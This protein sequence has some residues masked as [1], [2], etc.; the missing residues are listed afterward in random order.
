[1]FD[2]PQN[3]VKMPFRFHGDGVVSILVER[4]GPVQTVGVFHLFACVRSGGA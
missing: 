3:V 4:P 2:V 1:M